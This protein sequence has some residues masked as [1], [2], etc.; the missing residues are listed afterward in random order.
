M[1]Y[2]HFK[3]TTEELGEPALRLYPLACLHMGAAQCDVKF[4]DEQVAR[5]EADPAAR[6]VYMGDGG[7]C[8]TKLSKGDVYAQLLSPKDQMRAVVDL[9]EPI[10]AKGLFGVRG[11][12]GNRIYK[13]TGLDFDHNLCT[14]LGIPYM[15]AA[16]MANLVVNRSSYDGYFHHGT[17]SGTH[18]AAKVAKAEAF[19]RFINADAIVTAHSHVAMDLQPAALLEADNNGRKMRTKLR[20]QYICG[21]AYDSRTGYAEDRG[22]PPLLPSMIVIEFS[23][24]I[25]EGRAK[26][27]QSSR[28][29]RSDGAHELAHDYVLDYIR[30]ERG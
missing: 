8:V 2:L 28:V 21:S 14:I 4:I 6:W 16:V 22:Y 15:G 23:G 24:K 1:A 19:G 3:F 5:I 17:D 13:E 18:L 20:H 9:L 27:A 30:N 26:L 12:H 11:N 25:V 7:E 10:R 29:Y